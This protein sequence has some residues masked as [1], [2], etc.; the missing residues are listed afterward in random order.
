MTCMEYKAPQQVDLHAPIPHKCLPRRCLQPFSGSSPPATI[1]FSH[2]RTF[3]AV[4][5]SSTLARVSFHFKAA[6]STHI[7]CFNHIP[8]LPKHGPFGQRRH[9]RHREEDGGGNGDAEME[10]LIQKDTWHGTLYIL[11]FVVPSPVIH[12][13]L[14][15]V[16]NAGSMIKCVWTCLLP[17][18]ISV[19]SI[20]SPPVSSKFSPNRVSLSTPLPADLP[21][22]LLSSYF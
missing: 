13:A 8:F 17:N 6:F 20:S 2:K 18:Q 11:P 5:S 21:S 22:P 15:L 9:R 3:Q 1:P 7:I 12:M 14:R 16:R 19:N 4:P 10:E